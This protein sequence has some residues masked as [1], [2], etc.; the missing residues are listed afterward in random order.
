MKQLQKNYTTPE[1][2][3]KLLELGLPIESADCFTANTMECL[4]PIDDMTIFVLN[5]DETYT[6]R[7]DAICKDG[8]VQH[9]DYLPCWSV[10]RLI[11]I[12]IMLGGFLVIYE[13]DKN[14]I[15][16]LMK[17]ITIGCAQGWLDFEQ[18]K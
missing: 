5:R 4:S 15:E 6:Q 8:Y 11:E 10:G 2:S 17:E 18:L 1:Q 7:I 13:R 12:F 9:S 16:L 14:M 3:K